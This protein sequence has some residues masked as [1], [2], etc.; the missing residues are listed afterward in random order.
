MRG[1]PDWAVNRRVVALAE[2]RFA[3]GDA[4]SLYRFVEEGRS[5]ELH[6]RWQE[7]LQHNLAI[8]TGLCRW[9]RVPSLPRNN[10]NVPTVAGKLASWRSQASASWARRWRCRVPCAASIRA[11][12]AAA[13]DIGRCLNRRVR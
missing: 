7:Y 5:I 12:C 2:Q 4:P 11:K 10:P 3:R 13:G 1:A 6:P 9:N 8:V